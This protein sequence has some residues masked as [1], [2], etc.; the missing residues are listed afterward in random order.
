MRG[1]KIKGQAPIKLN[2]WNRKRGNDR[3]VIPFHN[4]KIWRTA[5]LHF[6]VIR[7]LCNYDMDAVSDI[8]FITYH[9]YSKIIS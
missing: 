6:L 3:N 2:E 9:N 4:Y 5:L 8:A 7:W 1:D